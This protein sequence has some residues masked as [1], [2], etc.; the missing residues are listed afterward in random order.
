MNLDAILIEM[1]AFAALFTAIVL[2]AYRGDRKYSAA[3]IYNYPPDIQE[4]YFKTHER[5]E[6]SYR[7]RVYRTG[8]LGWDRCPCRTVMCVPYGISAW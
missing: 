8:I 7:F 4:E 2:P 6:V 5:M 3:A 1:A